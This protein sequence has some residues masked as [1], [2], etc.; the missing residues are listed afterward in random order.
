MLTNGLR[1][2]W[3]YITRIAYNSENICCIISIMVFSSDIVINNTGISKIGIAQLHTHTNT[4]MLVQVIYP[5]MDD[6]DTNSYQH[7]LRFIRNSHTHVSWIGRVCVCS[8]VGG[9]QRIATNSRG[10]TSMHTYSPMHRHH[11]LAG[12]PLPSLFPAFCPF[13]EDVFFPLLLLQHTIYVPSDCNGVV[14]VNLHIWKLHA[15]FFMSETDA[16]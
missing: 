16:R 8:L 7:A 1:K 6:D 13:V 9:G 2:E 11:I 3:S 12:G 4:C 14:P 10:T 5:Y 15:R